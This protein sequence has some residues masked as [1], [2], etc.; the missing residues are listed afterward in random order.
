[1]PHGLILDILVPQTCAGCGKP[2]DGRDRCLCRRCEDAITPIRD[3][4]PR[5]SGYRSGGDCRVCAER[6][7]YPSRNITLAEYDG[8]MRKLLRELKFGGARALHA[9]I[10]RM[11]LAALERHKV[12]ADIIT[13]V[14]MNRKKLRARGYNQSRLIA[15]Y[16]SRRTGIPARPLLDERRAGRTQRELGLRDR[17]INTI[18][19][20]AARNAARTRERTVLLIDDVFTTGATVNECARILRRAGAKE[21][22]SLTI[23]RSEIKRLEKIKN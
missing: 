8:T 18:G 19:R 13:W 22:I 9:P 6:E 1:M 20:Y 10:G 21:V 3:H 17:F 11:A 15:T 5:C 16:L 23:A 14:P 7:F 12:T 2:V 4:C